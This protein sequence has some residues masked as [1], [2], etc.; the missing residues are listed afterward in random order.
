MG[1]N[2]WGV[3]NNNCRPPGQK[4]GLSMDELIII[5]AVSGGFLLQLII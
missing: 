3:Q 2:P 4:E 1:I 5:L